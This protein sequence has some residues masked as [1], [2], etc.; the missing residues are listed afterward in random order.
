[1]KILSQATCEQYP[2]FTTY[3]R[4]L[5][6]IVLCASTPAAADTLRLDA[7]RLLEKAV[8]DG[9]RPSGDGEGIELERDELFEDDGPAAGYSYKPNEE[10]LSATT[11]IKKEFVIPHPR[12]QKA[13][14]LVGPGGH[15]QGIVNGKPV[16]LQSARKVGQYWQ[17]Y[18]LPVDLLKP[19]KNEVILHGSGK[20]WIARADEF[21][22]GSVTRPRHANR[23]AKSTDGGKS[24]DYDRLGAAG[25]VGGEYYVRLF[26][27]RFRPQGVLTPPV[28][29]IG[30]LTGQPIAPPV[31]SLGKVRISA[32][33]E[34]SAGGK[35]VLR[36]RSGTTFVPDAKYWT[37]WEALGE[38]G[39]TID[40]PTGRYLQ[41]EVLLKTTDPLET[42]KLKQIKIEATPGRPKDWTK[43]VRVVETYNEEVVRTSIPFAYERF[44]HP[45]LKELRRT[46][47]LDE[48][49]SGSKS[50]FE[51]IT[52]LA[53]WSSKQWQRGHLRD[54]YPPWD[55]LEILKPHA[56]KTPVGGFCQ[57]YNVVFLQACESFGLVGRAVSLGSGDHGA[58]IRSG[59]EVVEIW[60]NEH[61]KWVYVDGH[62]ARYHIDEKSGQPLS[63]RELR[64]RQVALFRGKSS[65]PVK[66]VQFANGEPWQGFS[67][68][69]AFFE[70]R[71]IPRSNFLEHKAP[72]PLNQGM[73]GWFWT[74]HHVWTDADYPASVLYGNRV[75]SRRN[76]EW[77]L[78][79]TY[80]VLEATETPDIIR[81]NLD[82]E[83]PGF[84]TFLAHIDKKGPR[85]IASGF[86]WHL[87]DGP[88]RLEVRSRNVAGREG[89]TSRVV[90]DLRK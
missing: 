49:V 77:T 81:V 19:G 36:V 53:A 88:N 58:K 24:W 28:L 71:M 25:D 13:T 26:L 39:G 55:A 9:V 27:E 75:T 47:K 86:L 40:R 87:R 1:M 22:H 56:D 31:S 8:T 90:L 2:S 6:V 60:S 68:F 17:A 11:W 84:E 72:L 52:R 65:A 30:N 64:E 4:L 18:D 57:Q 59:H 5:M 78:N 66:A 51:L 29:D 44:D 12:T 79:Q 80:C 50:E 62:L 54:A 20:V 16:Q 45:G 43:D 10:K 38:R 33:T 41:L 37:A 46:Y 83:T 74:G 23:S 76:W 32:V 67:G 7:R 35:V 34:N 14:L 73:R 48:V 61:R 82:T 21:A 15:L 63:L 70:M 42:P 85:A 89:I 3:R 69:P